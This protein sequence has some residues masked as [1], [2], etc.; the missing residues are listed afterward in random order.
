MPGTAF[1]RWA[2]WMIVLS[3]CLAAMLVAVKGTSARLQQTQARDELSRLA[4]M[5][6][7]YRMEHSSY[8]RT[9]D[10]NVLFDSLMGRKNP[11]GQPG[12]FKRLID[13]SRFSSVNLDPVKPGNHLLDPWGRAY[14]YLYQ[15]SVQGQREGWL[16]FSAGPDGLSSD[17][18]T[19]AGDG[20]G[21]TAVDA[22]NIYAH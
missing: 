17:P 19:W 14:R 16:L 3:G 5:L 9:A 13:P 4:G 12:K 2:K 6:E 21:H 7:E 20:R 1:K 15:S 11:S 8:P 10:P 22:D 18:S